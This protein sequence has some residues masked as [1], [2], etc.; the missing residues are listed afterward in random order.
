M[1]L[2][3]DELQQIELRHNP[4]RRM[5]PWWDISQ[6]DVSSCEL[7]VWQRSHWSLA[8]DEVL[9]Y[10][11]QF[12]GITANG[13]RRVFVSGLCPR[14]W[15]KLVERYSEAER[16]FPGLG[17]FHSGRCAFTAQ[18]D[19]RTGVVYSLSFASEGRR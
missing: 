4:L 12:A 11:L 10:T 18:C 16:R 8:H 14:E 15:R 7:A 9:S 2:S 3:V 17:S 13:E 5:Q 6:S 1:I 19:P